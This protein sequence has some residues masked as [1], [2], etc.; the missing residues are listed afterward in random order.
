MPDAR[1]SILIDAQD[2]ANGV[3]ERLRANLGGVGGRG[4]ITG[5]ALGAT[6]ALSSIGFAVFGIQQIGHAVSG[7]ADGFFGFNSSLEQAA[8]TYGTLLGSAEAAQKRIAELQEFAAVTPFDFGQVLEADRLLETF[9]ARSIETLTLVGD[10]ASGTSQNFNEVAFWVGR[11]YSAI[12]AGRPFG[13]AAMRLQEMGILTAEGRSRIEALSE[14]GASSEEVW[15]VLN[16]QMGRFSGLMDDQS[17]SAKGLTST[18]SDLGTMGLATFTKPLFERYK[19]GIAALVSFLSAPRV[20][21]GLA[22]GAAALEK[23][24]VRAEEQAKRVFGWFRNKGVPDLL[25]LFRQI[26]PTLELALPAAFDGFVG[27]IQNA[28]RWAMW[29]WENGIQPLAEWIGTLLAK[30]RAFGTD[31]AVARIATV[32]GAIAGYAVAARIAFAGLSLILG[33]LAPLLSAAGLGMKGLSTGVQAIALFGGAATGFISLLAKPLGVLAAIPLAPIVSSLS[34]L[35]TVLLG[36]LT[37]NPVSLTIAAIAGAIAL[38]DKIDWKGIGGGIVDL[39]GAIK[40]KLVAA[41]GKLA[42]VASDPA[43]LAG[44][45][46]G[47]IYDA[48]YGLANLP[49]FVVESL[50][51]L[52]QNL[53]LKLAERIGNL[54]LKGIKDAIGTA[55]GAVLEALANAPGLFAKAAGALGGVLLTAITNFPGAAGKIASGLGTALKALAEAA[56]G[57][58][59]QAAKDVGNTILNFLTAPLGNFAEPTRQFIKNGLLEL[60]DAASVIYGVAKG[61]G[62]RIL[63]A[64][65]EGFVLAVDIAVRLATFLTGKIASLLGAA[66]ALIVATAKAI[67]SS[68]V[69]WIYQGI[70]NSVGFVGALASWIADQIQRAIEA[71]WPDWLPRP[72]AGV[73]ASGGIAPATGGGMPIVVQVVFGGPTLA[74]EA[75]MTR[76]VR[77]M[78][79]ALRRE[80][81]RVYA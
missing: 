38:W 29:L 17:R 60:A 2:R 13:E 62:K 9:G 11:A 67:G 15:A 81:D 71:A 43:S 21:D 27:A 74:T 35:G 79:P 34:L 8:I 61:I 36:L 31:P 18:L 63:D 40:D 53:L 46:A 16:E 20:Q 69:T 77:M 10:A 7:L 19:R 73:A 70:V 26:R 6:K 57:F 50:S 32:L 56:P 64:I 44:A 42:G 45:I 72:G 28:G 14:A 4:G 23:A 33:P 22:A 80:L 58:L 49:A 59:A 5:A 78:V 12:Q 65:G 24:L 51:K 48:I 55:L 3:L 66:G 52:A 30:A 68:I 39:A 54:P 25:N 41:I 1:V 47:I 75:E 37:L 76:A